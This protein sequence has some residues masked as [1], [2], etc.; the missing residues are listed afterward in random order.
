V[1]MHVQTSNN[2]LADAVQRKS[3]HGMQLPVTSLTSQASQSHR[4][5]LWPLARERLHLQHHGSA[6]SGNAASRRTHHSTKH[7]SA[8][9]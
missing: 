4:W 5:L 1:H 7:A 3:C 2:V 6:M 9:R 8:T